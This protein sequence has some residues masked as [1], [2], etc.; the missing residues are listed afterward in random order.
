MSG[1][2]IEW[3][4]PS[5]IGI[6]PAASDLA[7]GRLDRRVRARRVGGQH[8]RVA[9]V[10]DPQLLERVD[11][12]LEVRAGRA[13]RGADRPRREARARAGRRRGR[14]SARRRSRRRSRRARRDP[15]VYGSAAERR[16]G[17]RSRAS[18]R[19]SRQRSSGSITAR[20]SHSLGDRVQTLVDRACRTRLRRAGSRRPPRGTLRASE[21]VE[22]GVGA[23][24]DV[25]SAGRLAA[26]RSPRSMSPRPSVA[27]FLPSI[28]DVDLAV[29]DD[30]DAVALRRPGGS[31][32]TRA[33]RDRARSRA[34][35]ARGAELP[36]T[37]RWATSAGARSR[38]PA[39]SRCG[40]AGAG[41][42]RPAP[43]SAEVPGRPR[44]EQLG[45]PRARRAP[46]RGSTRPRARPSV[47][48][49]S[50]PK[51]RDRSSV[52]AVRW[53]SVRPETSSRL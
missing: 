2:A 20:F 26:A 36:A 23:R 33:R 3:S 16:A 46:A 49:S 12:G 25:R 52:G 53:S 15:A 27:S 32:S 40:R 48:P 6:A 38:S 9:E 1:S 29:R 17:P 22:P 21:R 41:C 45:R 34:R 30:V 50:T 39:R 51:T 42:D 10:D 11:L 24:D 14:R 35:R 28:D 18:R 8:R 4:P 31:A 43:R 7:D 44:S 5:T 13:A 37:R 47:S 19:S